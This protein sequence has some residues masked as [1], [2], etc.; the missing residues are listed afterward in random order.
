MFQRPNKGMFKYSKFGPFLAQLMLI[1]DSMQ[2]QI[3]V[4][5]MRDLE[6]E[7]EKSI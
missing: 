7:D 4:Y 1:H 2:M 5:S 6:D 3:I